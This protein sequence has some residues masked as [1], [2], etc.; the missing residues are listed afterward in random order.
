LPPSTVWRRPTSE[1]PDAIIT[2]SGLK[3]TPLD[4]AV[5]DTAQA[6]IDQTAM[7]LPHVKITELLLEVDEWTGFTRHFAHLKSGDPAKDKNLLLTTILADAI[8]PGL[9]KMAESCPGT[10]YAKLAWLQAWHI[11]DENLRGAALADLVNAQFRHPFA[12]HWGDGTTSSSDGQ[13]FRTGSK[14]ESTGH[15]NPKYGSSPGADVLH[16]HF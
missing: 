2:E 1:L 5:P 12:E 8:N 6:L 10:T 4:A 3:I 16:P 15:I 9:T 7:I 11:R 14:A 13:N